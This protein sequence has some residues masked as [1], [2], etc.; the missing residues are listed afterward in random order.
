MKRSPLKRKARLKSKG[1]KA[2]REE[3]AV[4]AFRA[5]VRERAEGLCE[6][7]GPA[8]PLGPHQGHHAHHCC[9]ADRRR[10]VHDPDRGLYVCAEAHRHIHDNPHEAYVRGWLWR[11]KA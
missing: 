1:R 11:S 5:A 4:A 10:G 7:N 2:K 8:C 9:I 6:A 3:P